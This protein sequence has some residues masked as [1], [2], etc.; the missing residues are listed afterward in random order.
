MRHCALKRG[1]VLPICRRRYLIRAING[2][3]IRPVTRRIAEFQN[4]AA[5]GMYGRAADKVKEHRAPNPILLSDLLCR[6]SRNEIQARTSDSAAEAVRVSADEGRK[7]RGVRATRRHDT[8]QT[9]QA[10]VRANKDRAGS[11]RVAGQVVTFGYNPS[12]EGQGGTGLHVL[13]V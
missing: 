2:S 9:G 7:G 13:S 5:T 4:T 3:G 6:P 8:S 12:N 1:S 10:H 11:R